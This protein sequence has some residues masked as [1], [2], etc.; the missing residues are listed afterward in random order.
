MTNS[1]QRIVHLE[2]I[3][4]NL[5]DTIA[6]MQAA[7]AALQQAQRTGQ[8]SPYSG[9][10][11]GGGVF[12]TPAQVITAGSSATGNVSLWVGGSA[13]AIASGATIWNKMGQSTASS[14]IIVLGQNPDGSFLVISQSC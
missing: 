4:K 9:G 8:Q 12:T 5:L 10:G 11:G 7:I 14:G 6:R 1:E 13:V 2:Q 3:I